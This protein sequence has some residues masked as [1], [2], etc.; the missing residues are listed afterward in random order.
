MSASPRAKKKRAILIAESVGM[1]HL[2]VAVSISV[3]GQFFDLFSNLI[4]EKSSFPGL[5]F[6]FEYLDR[7]IFLLSKGINIPY[8]N[9]L[10]YAVS[11]GGLVIVASTLVYGLIAYGVASIFL[12]GF[13]NNE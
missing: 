12:I 7:P 6:V 1:S 13:S 4:T 11:F 8:E 3:M 2:I 5:N 9:D 10:L